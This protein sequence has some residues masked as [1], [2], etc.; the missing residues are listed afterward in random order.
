MQPSRLA[1][2]D[3]CVCVCPFSA[4]WEPPFPSSRLD[5]EPIVEIGVTAPRCNRNLAA[6][7]SMPSA[8][9]IH[10]A[11]AVAARAV[12][13]LQRR[14]IQWRWAL[15]T[16]R[17]C[18]ARHPCPAIQHPCTRPLFLQRTGNSSGFCWLARCFF[19]LLHLQAHVARFRVWRNKSTG[20][21]T[22]C[23]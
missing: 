14:V 8:H 7:P 18:S 22:P 9:P 3:S 17:T 19:S 10:A 12:R 13:P 6:N 21:S 4:L 2:V 16:N 1:G 5:R 15:G 11:Q 20:S 23:F